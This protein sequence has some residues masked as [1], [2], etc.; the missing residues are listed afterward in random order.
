MHVKPPVLKVDLQKILELVV[1]DW[2]SF[3]K[4]VQLCIGI[5]VMVD[6]DSKFEYAKI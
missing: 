6:H 2:A 1:A 3:P 5:L 4:S